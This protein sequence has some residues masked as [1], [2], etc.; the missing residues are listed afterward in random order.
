MLVVFT[1]YVG[2]GGGDCTYVPPTVDHVRC[3]PPARVTVDINCVQGPRI[4]FAR[5]RVCF[6]PCYTIG[7]DCRI[8][9]GPDGDVQCSGNGGGIRL[10]FDSPQHGPASLEVMDSSGK[11]VYKRAD[12][13]PLP[14]CVPQGRLCYEDCSTFGFN[15]CVPDHDAGAA[16]SDATGAGGS[17]GTAG[18]GGTA[19]S[20]GAAGAGGSSDASAG[21]ASEAGLDSAAGAS[22]GGADASP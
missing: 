21:G 6:G 17:A 4:P 11:V 19:A 20:G 12:S 1:G 7:P 8:Y 14:E 16:D 10:S 13:Y 3:G 18:A 22:S 5:A 15:W 9:D 2:C